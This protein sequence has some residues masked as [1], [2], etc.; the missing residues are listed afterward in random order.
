MSVIMG[1][2]NGELYLKEAIDSILNQSF[3]NFEFIIV[4]DGSTDST[5]EI[6]NQYKDPRMIIIDQKRS[7]LTKSL[8]KAIKISS[9]ELIARQDAD[10]ISMHD[11]LARQVDFFDSNQDVSVVGT[12]Y[13]IVDIYGDFFQQ[14][15]VNNNYNEINDVLLKKL[16][17]FPH[18]SV[19]MKKSDIAQVDFYDERFTY[20]QDYNLWIRA[21]INKLKLSIIEESLYSFRYWPSTNMLKYLSQRKYSDISLNYFQNKEYDQDPLDVI[22][23]INQS[24]AN[25]REQRKWANKNKKNYYLSLGLHAIKVKNRLKALKCLSRAISHKNF[26]RSFL[27]ILIITLPNKL[28]KTLLSLPNIYKSFIN[29][30]KENMK[31]FRFKDFKKDILISEKNKIYSHGNDTYKVKELI[32]YKN[33][34]CFISYYSYGLFNKYNKVPFG[35]AEVQI[36]LLGKSLAKDEEIKINYLVGDFNQRELEKFGQVSIYKIYNKSNYR[37]PLLKGLQFSSNLIKKIYNLDSDVYI[38]RAAGYQTG[39]IALACKLF[40]KKFIY[41]TA[42]ETDCNRE[43]IKDNKRIVGLFYLIG[44]KLAD[45]VITQSKEHQRFLLENHGIDAPIIESSYYLSQ[46]NHK[47]KDT[48]LYVPTRLEPNKKPELFL[49]LSK[50]IPNFKFVLIGKPIDTHLEYSNKIIKEA[51][52]IDN[53]EYI[54]ELPLS[55]IDEYYKKAKVFVSTSDFEGFPASF[56][57]AMS[58]STPVFSLSVNPDNFLTKYK[59]GFFAEGSYDNLKKSLIEILNNNEDFSLMSGK[60]YEY[61]KKNHNLDINSKNLK[62]LI[63]NLCAE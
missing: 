59:C 11:R 20:S 31:E 5:S 1:V 42:S 9:S 60:A 56:V 26:Y 19:M 8:N 45:L 58:H 6:L 54:P 39:I 21:I 32:S 18:G 53:L 4:N 23:K 52:L 34:I 44:I 40:G 17:P 48:I 36:S 29:N 62:G 55:V 41:M 15:G 16:T 61:A 35:G 13:N 38:Q 14:V 30:K 3:E 22:Q 43:F 63:E 49:K 27:A 7:G 33:K 24:I 37:I 28:A 47:N 10:D 12:W 57:Q 51:K 50:E 46:Y 2:Y 25:D